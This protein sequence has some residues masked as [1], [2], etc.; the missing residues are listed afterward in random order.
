[1]LEWIGHVERMDQG[2]TVQI[3]FESKLEKSRIRGKPRHKWLE[4]MEKDLREMKV[5]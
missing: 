4:D 2:T 1:M 5:T 3:R